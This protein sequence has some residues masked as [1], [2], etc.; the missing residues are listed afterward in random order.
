VTR[1]SNPAAGPGQSHFSLADLSDRFG[2]RLQ[3]DPD[4]RVSG[5]ATLSGASGSDISFLS[6]PS[7]RAQLHSTQ[8]GAVILGQDDADTCPVNCLISDDPYSSYARIAGLFCPQPTAL[9]GI[10][11][12]A[13]V[14]D[15]ARIGAKVHVG[16]QAVIGPGCEIGEGASI[17]PGCVL[18]S[19]CR[20]GAEA[21]L[22]ANVTLC[23]GVVLGKRVII[24]PGAV[25]GADGFGL[26]FDKD[27]WIKVPQMGSV[28]I[29]DD[30]EIGA[31][32]TIDRGAIDNT[33]LE[34]DVRI[35]NLVQIGHNVHIGAHSALA[36]C[37]GISGSTRIGRY[38]LFAGRSGASGHLDIADR[39]TVLAAS[40]VL[41]SITEP[42]TTWSNSIPAQPGRE[43][44][45]TL[46]NLKRLDPLK[47]RLRALE[48]SLRNDNKND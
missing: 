2:L 36:G 20:I 30:S 43:W 45:R 22:V 40:V 48:K 18:L 13:V 25:I 26:A 17:G 7:Y 15:S 1:D 8:A 6:N 41:K 21:T 24:H 46:A 33:V 31:N 5:I 11:E 34:E 3:G 35:D 39:T 32:T 27:H 28:E 47:R 37:V 14:D 38:C 10:H 29:G 19:N 42:G 16:A 4:Y 12:S 23:E 44:N 9:P